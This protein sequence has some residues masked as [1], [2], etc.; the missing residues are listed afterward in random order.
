MYG[1]LNKAEWIK[2]LN[3]STLNQ[4]IDAF[5]AKLNEVHNLQEEDIDPLLQREIAVFQLSGA[6]TLY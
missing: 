5:E 1:I 2:K 4:I 3:D 6:T